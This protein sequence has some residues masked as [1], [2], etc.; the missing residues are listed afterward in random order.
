[1]SDEAGLLVRD[2]L[3][4]ERGEAARLSI[5][6]YS[7]YQESYDLDFW[8]GYK[9][10]MQDLWLQ[11]DLP[12]ERIAAF[13]DGRLLGCLLLY[14]PVDR[15]Y[16]KL[17]ATI[18]YHEIRLLAVHPDARGQGIAT[19]LIRECT[20]RARHSGAPFLGLHTTSQ[21]RAAVRLYR[22]LGFERAPEFDFPGS[23][24]STVV[25]AYRLPIADGQALL[26]AVP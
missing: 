1:M 26:T 16:E 17:E 13:R 11:E 9:Q 21:M 2:A 20:K 7:E 23:D 12:A 10:S 18:P 5:Q 6:A 22:R 4:E 8:A 25:E 3:P 19:R 15:L 14:P 24:A